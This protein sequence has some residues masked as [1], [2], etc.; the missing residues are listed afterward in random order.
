MEVFNEDTEKVSVSGGVSEKSVLA[1][2]N[3]LEKASLTE[4]QPTGLIDTSEAVAFLV[5]TLS[6]LPAHPP[7]IYVDLEGV[8]LS[9]RGTISILQL[10]I[11]PTNRTFLIDVHSLGEA[12]FTTPSS[13]GQT[14]KTILESEDVPKA[15][16]DVRNDSDALYSHFGINLA[17]ICDIQL[18]ELATRSFSKRCVNG[19]AKCIERDLKMTK[20]ERQDWLAN[21]EAGK[22]LFAPECGG[23]YEVFNVRPLSE[24]IL[25][26]CKQDVQ[27]LP[28]LWQHYSLKLTPKWATHV[29]EATKDRVKLS[30]TATFIGKG[31][32]MALG[33]WN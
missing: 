22:K 12:A 13:N 20:K 24:T 21:K 23:S 6:S 4:A 8:E 27:Y 28:R 1:V 5:S 31:R 29:K 33:P 17:G 9:R 26:Y 16:F 11:L 30:Q 25:Q 19:L 7:S 3:S 2:I 10:F 18:M 14:L 32:H 15:F